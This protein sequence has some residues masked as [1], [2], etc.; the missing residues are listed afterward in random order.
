MNIVY[1]LK[2]ELETV[3]PSFVV[4]TDE[5]SQLPEFHFFKCRLIFGRSVLEVCGHTCF[6]M[7][8]NETSPDVL[9]FTKWP[10]GCDVCIDTV[11]VADLL[12]LV[13]VK[14]TPT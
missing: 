6:S 14:R 1:D 10:H 13:R 4:V 3:I 11:Y 8:L 12:K 5:S 7:Q 2:V 9:N